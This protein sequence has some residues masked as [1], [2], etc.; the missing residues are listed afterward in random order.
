MQHRLSPFGVVRKKGNFQSVLDVYH[1]VVVLL[2]PKYAQY[3]QSKLQSAL[4]LQLFS[5]ECV[6]D[7]EPLLLV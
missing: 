2:L 1:L 6:T 4:V 3:F 5:L 7:Y